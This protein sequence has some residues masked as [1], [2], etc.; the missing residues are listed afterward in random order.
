MSPNF[1]FPAGLR[2]A[3]VEQRKLYYKKE[4][5]I[6]KAE[7]WLTLDNRTKGTIIIDV[8]SETT[9]YRPILKKYLNKLVYIRKFENLTQL[10]EKLNY[11]IPEDVYYSTKA[12]H[13]I[14]EIRELVFDLDPE[15]IYCFKCEI[16]KKMLP[17]K[18]RRYSFCDE[19]F[20]TISAQ[21]KDLYSLLEK[22][23]EKIYLIYSGRGFHIHVRD[24][25]A[26]LMKQ[27]EREIL[28]EKVKKKFGIDKWVTSGNIDI[29]RLPGT[30]NGLVSRKVIEIKPKDLDDPEKIYKEKA[31]PE[32]LK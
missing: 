1:F 32:F 26:F 19:C 24:D 31:V 4:F 17:E 12:L 15:N 14:R 7:K 8:G 23:F 2:P 16:R 9:R 29:I 18:G 30:L 10:K 11:Y 27:Q 22:H 20:K 25:F 21:T 28:A 13:G 6:E 3:T 5:D